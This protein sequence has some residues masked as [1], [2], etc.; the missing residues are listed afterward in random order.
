MM[1]LLLVVAIG[2]STFGAGAQHDHAAMLKEARGATTT[3]SEDQIA[4]LLAGEGMG[5]AKPAELNHYPGPKHVIEL[6]R[7]LN[8]TPE[9]RRR[10]EKIRESMLASARDLG[11]R[12][13]EAERT[14]DLRFRTG[15]I[16]QASLNEL[17][18]AIGQLQAELRAVHLG[19]HL[20]TQQ[21]LTAGQIKEYDVRRG[22]SK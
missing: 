14:L 11:A 13:V 22:Y 6:A 4:Q 9:Q 16:D 20:T 1:K 3:L 8:L 19:A 2:S 18:V 21:I 15:H 10:V 12:I 17:T 5:L 7:E